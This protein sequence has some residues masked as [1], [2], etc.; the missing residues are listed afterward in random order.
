MGFCL[1]MSA[2]SWETSFTFLVFLGLSSAS[3]SLILPSSSSSAASSSSSST[4]FSV[5]F[6][7]HREM[8]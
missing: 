7:V 4:S 8:G 2:H 3:T 5:V 6:S 1:F